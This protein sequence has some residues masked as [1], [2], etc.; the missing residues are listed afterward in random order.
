M[1][2]RNPLTLTR[3]ELYE[4][5]W[6]KPMTHVAADLGISDV[7]VAKRCRQVHV[8]V[9][10]RG[11][12]ARVAGGQTPAKPPLPR[13][14]QTSDPS[15]RRLVAPPR[16]ATLLPPPAPPLLRGPEPTVTFRPPLKNTGP[17]TTDATLATHPL[18]I[19]LD[20]R[21]AG[22]PVPPDA[23]PSWQRPKAL[24]APELPPGWPEKLRGPARLPDLSVRVPSLQLRARRLLTHLIATAEQLG[25]RFI[26]RT[27][28]DEGPVPYSRRYESPEETIRRRAHWLV[29]DELMFVDVSERHAYGEPRLAVVVRHG[30]HRVESATFRDLVR[31]PL[32]A[33][34]SEI[35]RTLL[36][37][38]LVM[39]KDRAAAEARARARRA[40]EIAAEQLRKSREAHLAVIAKLES[41]AGA[42]ERARR[43]RRYLRAARRALPAD[44]VFRMEVDG[45]AVDIFALGERFADQIDPLSPVPRDPKLE[46]DKSPYG[47]SS[48]SDDEAALRKHLSRLLGRNWVHSQKYRSDA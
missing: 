7:A 12:W 17:N 26:P 14:R 2:Q 39:K 18:R 32:E 20:E 16:P 4:M 11:Y 27:E 1:T 43:L 31:K 46:P 9:P 6:S 19:A 35:L 42:W 30:V 8:P 41:E 22:L 44:R 37:V 15:P 24:D 5:V 25:W 21:L 23:P 34:V 45:E 40:A 38:A 13:Y 28:S 3:A 33:R 36:D 48:Y 29:E 47:Y 10:P